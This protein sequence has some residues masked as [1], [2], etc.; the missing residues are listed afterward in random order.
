M[1]LSF[2]DGAPALIEGR[3]GQGRVLVFASTFDRSWTDLPV[4]PGFV[5]LVQSLF[6]Y[7]SDESAGGNAAAS[8]VGEPKTISLP[9][10]KG[11]RLVLTAP[12]KEERELVTG[13][14]EERSEKITGLSSPGIWRLA[15]LTQEGKEAR[16]LVFS[17][18]LHP[19]GSQLNKVDPAKLQKL[20]EE[21]GDGISTE[22]NS[23]VPR[24]A[25]LAHYLLLLVMCLV[26]GESILIRRG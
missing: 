10:S 8:F 5:P 22:T 11:E 3:L 6:R 25:P 4:R 14:N 16:S 15:S 2:D 26:L 20:M 9:V 23:E 7:A 1:I 18:V 17:V 19:A 24:G 12:N 13:I 21:S